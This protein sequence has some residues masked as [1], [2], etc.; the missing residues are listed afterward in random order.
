VFGRIIC[1]H[2]GKLLLEESAGADGNETEDDPCNAEEDEVDESVD[3]CIDCSSLSEDDE[4]SIVLDAKFT[5]CG[6]R[7]HAVGRCF[8]EVWRRHCVLSVIVG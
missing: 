4:A 7:P 3:D 1:A 6:E 8:L 2:Q 5:F